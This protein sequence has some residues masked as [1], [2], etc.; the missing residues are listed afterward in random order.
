MANSRRCGNN[1]VYDADLYASCPYCSGQGNSIQFGA[2]GNDGGKT[3][4]PGAGF[5]GTVA[6]TDMGATVFSGAEPMGYTQPQILP[7]PEEMGKTV[8]PESYLDRQRREGK[9]IGV[10]KN[11]FSLDPVVG[12]MVCIEGPDQGRSYELLARINFIGRGDKADVKLKDMTISKE[13][14]KLGYDVKHNNFYLIPG[15]STNTT[16]LNDVPLYVPTP[17]AAYDLVEMG[18]SKLMFIPF[19]GE[20]FQWSNVVKQGE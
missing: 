15:E 2:F 13:Q 9:T 12:W 7:N 20:R 17:I 11:K 5:G 14:A 16:Y 6:P 19:C 3:F 10:F 4:A 8:A 18:E 1:H